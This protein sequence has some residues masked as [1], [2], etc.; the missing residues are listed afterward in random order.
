MFFCEKNNLL[1]YSISAKKRWPKERGFVESWKTTYK[2]VSH[3]SVE[4]IYEQ[5]GKKRMLRCK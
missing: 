5:I 3:K 2:G 1:S 4:D